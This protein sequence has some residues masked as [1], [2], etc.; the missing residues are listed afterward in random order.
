MKPAL[1]TIYVLGC[2]MLCSCSSLKPPKR[3]HFVVREEPMKVIDKEVRYELLKNGVVAYTGQTNDL[4]YFT[5]SRRQLKSLTNSLLDSV[6]I[7]F[8]DNPSP[9]H[10]RLNNLSPWQEI[11]LQGSAVITDNERIADMHYHVS[12]RNH[13]SWSHHYYR[14]RRLL[15]RPPDHHNWTRLVKG[16]KV[17]HQSEGE[18]KKPYVGYELDPSQRASMKLLL[19]QKW[20]KSTEGAN[21]L[22]KYSQATNP[23]LL[24]GQ[25]YLAFNAISPFEHS[26]SNQG[27]KRTISSYF[28]SGVPLKWLQIMGGKGGPKIT[29]W[30]NFNREY[31]MITQ[32]DTTFN[33]FRWTWLKSGNKIAENSKPLVINV[34]EGGHIL[35]DKYFPH[36][37]NYDLTDNGAP[38]KLALYNNM[39][40]VASEFKDSSEWDYTVY[41]RLAR[42]HNLVDSTNRAWRSKLNRGERRFLRDSLNR[43]L[44]LPLVDTVLWEE[45]RRSIDTLKQNRDIYMMAISHLSYNGMTGHAPA[46]D[47]SKKPPIEALFS[48]VIKRAYG[49]RVSE[50]KRYRKSFDGLFYSIPGIN[51]FGDSVINRL[52]SINGGRRIH[53]DL[54]HSDVLAR[55][56]I[57]QKYL[58]LDSLPPICSHCGVNGLPVDYNSPFVNEYQLL[59]SPLARKFYTFGMNLYNEEVRQI[60]RHQGIIGIPL[61]ERVLGGYVNNKISWPKTIEFKDDGTIVIHQQANQKSKKDYMIQAVTAASKLQPAL[62]DPIERWYMMELSDTV[63]RDHIFKIICEEYFSAESFLNNVFHVVDLARLEQQQQKEQLYKQISLKSYNQKYHLI[64]VVGDSPEKQAALDKRPKIVQA[65]IDS[66]M[67]IVPL[68]KESFWDALCIGSDLDGLIDPINICPTAS[69]YPMFKKKLALFI[70]LFLHVRA[71]YEVEDQVLGR[72]PI[73]EDYFGEGFTINHAL[74]K[75]FYTNLKKFAINNFQ[76]G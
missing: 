7:S 14:P 57:F 76:D 44:K 22:K 61:E 50:D 67:S 35:Q 34:V 70:P 60:V 43:Y 42:R 71:T 12:M 58:D 27:I 18:W 75:L 54:K 46:I 2:V 56:A 48:K 38:E 62:W 36:F 21:N 73:Y 51:Y 23:H 19:E 31:Q 40:Q 32:Q 37:I 11:Y 3:F 10:Y 16:I 47:V 4:G 39:L 1:L 15:A 41:E 25:V 24:D 66:L 45:L 74:T 55:K 69:Q 65:Q 52:L 49:N 26:I 72:Y 29:H 5:F 6:E 17:W 9:E 68:D 20:V 8:P 53:I 64:D 28:K 33:K 30:D 63:N 59:E 13:N